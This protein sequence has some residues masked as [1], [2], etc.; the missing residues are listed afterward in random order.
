MVR[1]CNAAGV[2]VI[3]DTVINHMRYAQSGFFRSHTVL[4][5]ALITPGVLSLHRLDL[6]EMFRGKSGDEISIL[7]PPVLRLGE[8]ECL[9]LEDLRPP[10]SHDGA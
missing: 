3:A 8:A 2:N 4:C 6:V 9:A 1:R 10:H 7:E 5:Y